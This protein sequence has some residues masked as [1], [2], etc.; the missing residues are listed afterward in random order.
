MTAHTSTGNTFIYFAAAPS[1]PQLPHQILQVLQQRLAKEPT[2]RLYALV[3]CLAVP[4]FAEFCA[5]QGWPAP[6]STYAGQT[7]FDNARAVAPSLQELPGDLA[8]LE[9]HMLPPLL[10]HCSGKPALGFI[11][12]LH[13]VDVVKAQLMRVAGVTDGDGSSWLLRFGDTRVW[14]PK[15]GLL[16]T[17]QHAHAFAGLDAWMVVDRHGAVQTF[18]GSPDAPPASPNDLLRDFR[19]TAQQFAQMIE[20]SE[21]DAH[22]ARLA[23]T[24]THAQLTCSP[25]EQYDTARQCLATLDR[26]GIDNEQERYCYIR[27]ALRFPG[28]CEAHPA[29]QDALFAASQRRGTL[30]VQLAALQASMTV[31]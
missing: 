14:P 2:L 22:L 4:D 15:P 19:M 24:P 20:W 21:A 7:G 13:A 26:L 29:V 23:Q 31:A 11:S 17:E 16:T 9:Q 18:E 8:W 6:V 30:S 10:A 12:S 3:D 5:Q 28:N 27:F 25:I 1:A